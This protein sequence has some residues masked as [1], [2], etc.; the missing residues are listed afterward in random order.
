M[1][2]PL[3]PEV[4]ATPR[5]LPARIPMRG[6]YVSLEPLHRRHA[7]ELWRAAQGADESWAYLGNGPFASREAM[8]RV[9]EDLAAVHEPMFWAVRPVVTGVASGWLALAD[10]QPRTHRL[11]WAISGS[12]RACSVPVPQPRLSS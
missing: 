3:G 4:D 11:S 8:A 2:P 12:A 7:E 5:A 10:I 1:P 9:V 6:Q